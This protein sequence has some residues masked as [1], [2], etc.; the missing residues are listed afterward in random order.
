MGWV[1]QFLDDI[2]YSIKER[3]IDPQKV[4]QNYD[5]DNSA[6]LEETEIRQIASAL[7]PKFPSKN[8]N[9]VCKHIAKR[10]NGKLPIKVLFE[11]YKSRNSD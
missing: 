5:R 9:I 6:T 2:A 10:F 1:T 3:N 8:L 4:F 7:I 11:E